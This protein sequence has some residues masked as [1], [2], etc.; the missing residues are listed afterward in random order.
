MSW[1]INEVY[2]RRELIRLQQILVLRDLGLP[3]KRVAAIL[4]STDGGSW[5]DALRSHRSWLH[6]ASSRWA[7]A[8]ASW[9]QRGDA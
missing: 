7:W 2:G 4:D 5:A 8:P 1:S 9:S 6:Q 3:L